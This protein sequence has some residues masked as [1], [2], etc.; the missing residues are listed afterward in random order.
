MVDNNQLTFS[1][2]T[3]FCAKCPWRHL[4]NAIWNM[5]NFH[6]INRPNFLISLI[7]ISILLLLWIDGSSKYWLQFRNNHLLEWSYEMVMNLV[8]IS[9]VCLWTAHLS[10]VVCPSAVYCL[11]WLE[12]PLIPLAWKQALDVAWQQAGLA[13]SIGFSI[14]IQSFA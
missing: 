12:W 7:F 10:I 1:N 13:F 2:Y 9:I 3:Y 6:G 11:C 5:E 14:L 4:N 8:F